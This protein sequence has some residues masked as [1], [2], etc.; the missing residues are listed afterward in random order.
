MDRTERRI[1]LFVGIAIIGFVMYLVVRDKEFATPELY[2]LVR[3]IISLGI[4][5]VAGTVPGFLGVSGTVAGLTLRAGGGLA[6][7]VITYFF[8]P[9]TIPALSPPP[10]GIVSI[11]PIK[12]VDFRTIV[13]A[14]ASDADRAA[15]PLAVM[16]PVTARNAVQPS[17][18]STIEKT[19]IRFSLEEKPYVF[20]WRDFV[21]MDE[22]NFGKWLGIL[23][24]AVPYSVPSGA[25]VHH[26]ILH[27]ADGILTW[28]EFLGAVRSAKR[29]FMDVEIMIETDQGFVTAKCIADMRER[30]REIEE[31][32]AKANKNP[33]RITTA[34]AQGGV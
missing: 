26:E 29:D 10:P 8:S 15:A 34:C 21:Q 4:G 1:G 18:V 24:D 6:A 12:I 19:Q 25:V 13:A 2:Q 17:L 27:T 33:G 22:E 11:D 16:M 28:G 3:I 32:I 7:F 20:P 5:V 30:N 9:G 23:G 14:T 31:F